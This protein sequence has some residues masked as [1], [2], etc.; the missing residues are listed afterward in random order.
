MKSIRRLSY[1]ALL[2]AFAQIVFGAIVRITG[3][4]WGCGEHWPKCAGYWL[5]PLQR[6]DLVIEVSHR[7]L[8]LG[9]T[10]VTLALA[11]LAWRRRDEPGVAGRGGPLRPAVAAFLVVV[12]TALLG[13]ITIKLR[14]NPIVIVLHLAL[15]MTLLAAIIATAISSGGFGAPRAVPAGAD[16]AS[17]ADAART[18]RVARIGLVLAFIVLVL[19]ALTAN[20]GAAG[21]CLG[22]PNCRIYS[23]P[24]RALV[25]L[26]LTH[27]I[28]AFLFAFHVLGA[29]MMV[30]KR[31]VAPVVRRAI[32]L[33]SAAVVV[34]LLVAAALVEM[35]LPPVLQSLHQA[36]G[37]LAWIAVV[38]W[39]LLA[40]RAA[41]P[42]PAYL[43]DR[44]PAPVPR[45][46]DLGSGVVRR[47]EPATGASLIV[48]SPAIDASAV[49][50]FAELDRAGRSYESA[51]TA[52]VAEGEAIA[53]GFDESLVRVTPEPEAAAADDVATV[54]AVDVTAA[55]VPAGVAAEPVVDVTAD[56]GADTRAGAGDGAVAA[57]APERPAAESPV[58]ETNYSHYVNNSVACGEIPV[59]AVVAP[60]PEPEAI[61]APLPGPGADPR[62]SPPAPVVLPRHVVTPAQPVPAVKRPP[63]HSV[64]VIVARGA[65]F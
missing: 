36:V 1:T 40:H 31:A 64:A 10:L 50:R 57:P 29:A 27:R 37:T 15:A 21:A 62:S 35:R 56:A 26:Q 65:D 12:A 58:P 38:I 32:F 63:P 46:R 8:A 13:A 16:D 4:G 19:G 41:G 49:A 55:A 5:P 7:Y 45:A 14:L 23:S 44:T 51:I 39:A 2:I 42:E 17:R 22:F 60:L 48:S 52:L 30:R 11:I 47:T 3:S 61:I 9:V 20:L 6:P 25:H 24:D 33:A 43:A 18:W 59:E 54:R 34:Q 53:E 28:L